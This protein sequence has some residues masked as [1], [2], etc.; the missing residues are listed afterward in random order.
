[1]ADEQQYRVAYMPEARV[2]LIGRTRGLA[3]YGR[4]RVNGVTLMVFVVAP[5]MVTW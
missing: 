2:V 4:V 5:S 1:M 3:G